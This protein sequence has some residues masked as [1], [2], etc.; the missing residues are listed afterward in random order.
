MKYPDFGPS[1]ET[2]HGPGL[3]LQGSLPGLRHASPL[4][5]KQNDH[6]LAH[7]SV[8]EPTL[9]YSQARSSNPAT[10]FF[11]NSYQLEKSYFSQSSFKRCQSPPVLK[12]FIA[13]IIAASNIF[14]KKA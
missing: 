11:P 10:L 3:E 5:D 14:M 7:Q 12:L 1:Y 9:F 2:P 8:S 6:G 13:C 4:G